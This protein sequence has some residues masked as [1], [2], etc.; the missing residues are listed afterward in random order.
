MEKDAMAKN[1]E[2][3]TYEPCT[4]CKRH[5]DA[6]DWKTALKCYLC[7]GNGIVVKG[8][9]CNGCGESLYPSVPENDPNGQIPHGLE[10]VVLTGGYDSLGSLISIATPSPS[11]RRVSERRS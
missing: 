10:N 4:A 9:V 5:R 8:S 6:A 2:N 1:T 11:A 3:V 7:G